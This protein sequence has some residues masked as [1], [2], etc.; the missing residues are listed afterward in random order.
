MQR[1]E[2]SNRRVWDD[3]EEQ[4]M[5]DEVVQGSGWPRPMSEELRVWA[6]LS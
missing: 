1:F 3:K 2:G 6:I 5:N 4:V